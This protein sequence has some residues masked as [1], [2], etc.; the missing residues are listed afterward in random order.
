MEEVRAGHLKLTKSEIAAFMNS[1]M[2]LP[3]SDEDI[4]ALEARTEGGLPPA[5][6]RTFHAGSPGCA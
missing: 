4:G 2:H 5:T 1:L 6:G 3:L